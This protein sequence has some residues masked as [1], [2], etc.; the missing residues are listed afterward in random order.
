M[1]YLHRTDY[2]LSEEY[3]TAGYVMQLSMNMNTSS[4]C[5]RTSKCPTMDDARELYG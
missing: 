4:Q 5:H 1:I 2:I 3:E